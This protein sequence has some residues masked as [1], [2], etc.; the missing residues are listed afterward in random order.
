LEASTKEYLRPGIMPEVE[1][2]SPVSPA[3][4]V[5]SSMIATPEHQQQDLP[6]L[7]GEPTAGDSK[8]KVDVGLARRLSWMRSE[9]I[10]V[11]EGEGDDAGPG[12]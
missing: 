9:K 5:T 8:D 4:S 2:R 6:I 11:V 10:K 7:T 12:W 3:L 1:D